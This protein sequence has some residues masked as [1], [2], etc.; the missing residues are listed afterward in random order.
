MKNKI[1][2]GTANFQ[3]NYG[4]KGKNTKKKNII[5]LLKFGR[6]EKIFKVDTSPSYEK[7]ENILGEFS[8]YNFKIHTKIPKLR[9]NIRYDQIEEHIS[10]QVKQSLKNLKRKKIDCI[11]IQNAKILKTQKGKLIYKTLSILKKKKIIK[12][13]GIS[14]YDL[15]LIDFVINKYHF[16]VAQVPLNILDQR[17]IKDGWLRKLKK[18]KIEVHV[19]SLFLQGVL[20]LNSKQLPKKLFRLKKIWHKLDIIKKKNDLSNIQFA[21]IPFINNPLID[22]FVMGFERKSQLDEVLK[23]NKKKVDFISKINF[24]RYSLIDPLKWLKL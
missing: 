16:D 1:I 13:I 10:S 12:K 11:F 23:L 8:K 22:G 2:I 21:L 17:L 9:K 7:A 18:N 24:N 3:R 4:I 5:E 14:I 6:K 19:R 15:K 20:L